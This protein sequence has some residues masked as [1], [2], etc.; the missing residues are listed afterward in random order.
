[1]ST[2][3]M[4][5]LF[6]YH[7]RPRFLSERLLFREEGLLSK[8]WSEDAEKVVESKVQEHEWYKGELTRL[9]NIT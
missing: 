7:I 5:P 2:N 4:Y 6:T 3:A 8:F 9:L 1:M